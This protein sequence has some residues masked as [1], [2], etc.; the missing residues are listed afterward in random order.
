MPL[1][2]IARHLNIQAAGKQAF[3]EAGAGGVQDGLEKEKAM[4]ISSGE[5]LAD[6]KSQS[7]LKQ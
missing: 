3:V 7:T 4:S 5:E 6:I 2:L 1:E